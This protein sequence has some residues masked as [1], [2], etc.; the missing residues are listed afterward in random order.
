MLP[1]WPKYSPDLNPQENVW[2][3]AETAIRAIEDQDSKKIS[4][5]AFKVH[6]IKGCK[7]YTGSEKLI[8][9]MAKRMRLLIAAKGGMIKY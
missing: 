1:N 4:F 6:I 3:W 9:S 2:A 5:D 8:P 7:A